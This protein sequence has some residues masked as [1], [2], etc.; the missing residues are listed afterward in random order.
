MPDHQ[1][2]K[3]LAKIKVDCF[4]NF[5]TLYKNNHKHEDKKYGGKI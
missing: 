3:E 1:L 2:K 4:I 5:A